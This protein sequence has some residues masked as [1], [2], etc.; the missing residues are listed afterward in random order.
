[1]SQAT[2]MQLP[3]LFYRELILIFGLALFLTLQKSIVF[4]ATRCVGSS[5]GIFL[6]S[7]NSELLDENALKV[8]LVNALIIS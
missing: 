1:M 3:A 7:H 5:V 6:P 4:Y 8:V 2:E